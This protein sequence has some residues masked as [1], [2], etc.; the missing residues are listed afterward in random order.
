MDRARVR[1]ERRV[2]G[3]F[4]HARAESFRAVM[5]DAR[6]RAA[7][8][9]PRECRV[10]PLHAARLGLPELLPV[11]RGV[12]DEAGC[13]YARRPSVG[14]ARRAAADRS[15]SLRAEIPGRATAAT[16]SAL[17]HT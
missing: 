12:R 14:R 11:L 10:R 13:R 15:L 5:V 16:R 9:D 7:S 4:L 1:Q 6:Y 3:K 8:R 17:D 2:D